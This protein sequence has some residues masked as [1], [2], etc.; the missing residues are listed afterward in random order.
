MDIEKV[1]FSNEDKFT[2]DGRDASKMG[3][4]KGLSVVLHLWYGAAFL[5]MAY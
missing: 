5:K 1:I 4:K 3:D 2:L